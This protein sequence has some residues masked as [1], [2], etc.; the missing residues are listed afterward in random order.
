MIEICLRVLLEAGLGRTTGLGRITVEG[1]AKTTLTVVLQM[2]FHFRLRLSSIWTCMSSGPSL[3]PSISKT[4]SE[5]SKRSRSASI[6]IG[7]RSPKLAE[8][9]SAGE[10]IRYMIVVDRGVVPY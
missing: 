1:T 6:G 2:G 5:K 4:S 7:S 3:E 8:S 10:F 9:E